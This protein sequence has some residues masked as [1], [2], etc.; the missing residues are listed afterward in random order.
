MKHYNI[1]YLTMYVM[2]IP[3]WCGY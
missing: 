3:L 1:I 2:V